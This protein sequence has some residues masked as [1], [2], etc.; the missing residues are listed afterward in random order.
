MLANSAW[1]LFLSK[2]GVYSRTCKSGDLTPSERNY[3]AIQKER[4]ALFFCGVS[5]PFLFGRRFVDVNDNDSLF[6]LS[7]RKTQGILARW[8][9]SYCKSATSTATS[10]KETIIRTPMPCH[11]AS[12]SI[13][14]YA[15]LGY[16]R[17]SCLPALQLGNPV[18][19][20][21]INSH[22]CGRHP[23]GGAVH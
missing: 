7:N 15:W 5:L 13:S 19:Q 18:L 23:F 1:V 10:N 22:E 8:V 4:L 14:G 11:V 6:W 17:V 3:S 12:T 21:V 2:V 20:V 9:I 16:K